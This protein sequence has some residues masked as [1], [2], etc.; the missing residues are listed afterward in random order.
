MR[1]KRIIIA[2]VGEKG[3]SYGNHH[4]MPKEFLELVS[5][6][7]ADSWTLTGGGAIAY[8][9]DSRRVGGLLQRFFVRAESLR[10]SMPLLGIGV[11]QEYLVGQFDW[12]GRLK[13][14]FHVDIVVEQRALDGI[15]GAQTYQE[16]LKEVGWPPNTALEPT[17]TAP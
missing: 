8:F 10:E 9:L 1:K 13:R 14:N 6:S 16:I 7:G 15:Q 4:S 17:P 12:L 5:A 2:A 11:T 3:V